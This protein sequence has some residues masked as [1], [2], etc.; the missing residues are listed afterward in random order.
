MR[1]P[2]RTA[3]GVIIAA[4]VLLL[5][6]GA[7]PALAFD[8]NT[9][10]A[11]LLRLI[12]HARTS[13]GLHAV[14]EHKALNVA[15][16]RHARDMMR[17]DYFS[18][19]SLGGASVGTR[20]RR[21]GYSRSGYSRWTVGEVIGWGSGLLGTPKAVFRAWMKSKSHRAVIL[22]K[23]WR[24]VG[25]GCAH[26]TFKGISNVTMYAVDVGRRVQ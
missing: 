19:V 12:N 8:H 5:G 18:H 9:N 3:T 14:Q 22:G 24:D 17:R 20:V 16:L 25:L 4:F 13:R 6:V 21:A 10:E 15:S 23:R 2:L 7:V 11:T 26:G 1:T